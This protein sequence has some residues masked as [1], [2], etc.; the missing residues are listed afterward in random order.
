MPTRLQRIALAT[1]LVIFSGCAAKPAILGHW[2]SL[3]GPGGVTFKADGTFEAV[4]NQGMPVDG[5]YRIKGSDGIQFEIVHENSETE[6][7]DARLTQE[8]DRLTLIFP[9]QEAVENY[10]RIP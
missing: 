3:D 8:S 7:I 10:R 4:D 2:Q 1:L 6:S 5:K 9:D